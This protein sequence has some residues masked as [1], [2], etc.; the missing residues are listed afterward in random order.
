M[1]RDLPFNSPHN[2]AV[3]FGIVEKTAIFIGLPDAEVAEMFVP[4][5][6]LDLEGATVGE[7]ESLLVDGL[8]KLEHKHGSISNEKIVAI[9]SAVNMIRMQVLAAQKRRAEVCELIRS[10]A[11]TQVPRHRCT[12]PEM[13]L[14]DDEVNFWMRQHRATFEAEEKQVARRAHDKYVLKMSARQVEQR[15]GSRF[16]GFLKYYFGGSQCL[17]LYLKNRSFGTR[18]LP[19]LIGDHAGDPGVQHKPDSEVKRYTN[20]RN[21]WVAAK[22][23]KRY[24]ENLV[25]DLQDPDSESAKQRKTR[26]FAQLLLRMD[27]ARRGRRFFHNPPQKG[28]GKGRETVSERWTGQLV[29][30]GLDVGPY[31]DRRRHDQEWNWTRKG[32]GWKGWHG[33]QQR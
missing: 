20:T 9:E 24:F 30:A 25:R 17:K 10:T 16:N 21:W 13:V 18:I 19:Q 26:R 11:D 2:S 7:V 27:E 12:E 33:W 8:I 4:A 32:S 23:R 28:M 29:A 1:K 22:A 14:T 3:E 31:T 6:R 15:Q 5:L